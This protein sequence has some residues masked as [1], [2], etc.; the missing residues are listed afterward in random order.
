[1]DIEIIRRICL[2]RHLFDLGK[3]S[4]MTANDLHLFSAVN[5]LQ[6]SVEAFMLAVADFVNASVSFKTT[7][8]QYFTLI[9]DKISPK[10]LPFKAK[11]LR[12]NKIRV[13][14]KHYGIM[15]SRSEC[16]PLIVSIKEFFEEVSSSIL[17]VNFSTVSTLD[18]LSDRESKKHL[19]EAKQYL[20]DG[21]YAKCAISCRKA[22]YEELL[23]N[24]NIDKFIDPEKTKGL[25]AGFSYAPYHTRNKEYI[26]KNVK[27]PT[28]YIV[29]D[30]SH[31]DSEL[32]KYS[33]D[34]T[35]FWNVWRLTPEVYK[36]PYKTWVIKNDF[37]KIDDKILEDKIEYIFSS[38]VDMILAIHVV[39]NNIKTQE[40][41]KFY[42][43]LK[44]DKVPI[45][46]KATSDAEVIDT[47]PEGLLKLDCDYC[48]DGLDG[49][50]PYWKISHASDDKY[51]SGYI[52][53]KH[54]K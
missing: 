25:L 8:D 37:N 53:N 20:E 14:S 12:L 24:Y 17:G 5:L 50:G 34:N 30:H 16:E 19:I 29:I 31:L 51:I 1:M 26:E 15:P 42:L 43:E 54:L 18:L 48:I 10:E 13:N 44:E 11:L 47:T 46:S 32:V 6:D 38:T 27:V 49:S 35:M 40:H 41:N 33:I 2:S 36:S 3:S 4:L 7:F 39:R 28:D 52:D 21:N 9:N 45:L 22:I 23:W